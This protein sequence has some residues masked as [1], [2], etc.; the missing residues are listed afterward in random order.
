MSLFTTLLGGKIAAGV[1]AAGVVAAGATGAAA[2]ANILP[3]PLQQS[4]HALIGA[5]APVTA[6]TT[7]KVYASQEP[8]PTPSASPTP[9]PTA[10]AQ[11]PDASGPAAYG[12]CN[13]YLHGGLNV[14][15]T[16]YTSLVT[17]AK[18]SANIVSYCASVPTPGKSTVH[19]S[20]APSASPR[21]GAVVT[22]HG[23]ANAAPTSPQLPSQSAPGV[24]HKP[25][26]AGKP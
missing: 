22:H 5:P 8:S 3:A 23:N 25:A 10:T 19:R 9:S 20:A 1:L 13:A 16:A 11:G 4:A 18:G 26:T 21:S 24:S 17:A 2:Y 7:E 14:S 6:A 15:S 12:L